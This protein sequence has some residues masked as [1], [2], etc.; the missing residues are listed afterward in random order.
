MVSK[1]VRECR[2]QAG[3]AANSRG[4]Q[5]PEATLKGLFER[6]PEADRGHQGEQHGGAAGD[7][8]LL[9]KDQ[10]GDH[11]SIDRQPQVVLPAVLEIG[12]QEGAS[13]ITEAA[14]DQ[15]SGLLGLDGLIGEEVDREIRQADQPG[16]QVNREGPAGT[17]AMPAG[18]WNRL[19]DLQILS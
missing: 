3:M 12:G 9:A 10:G 13:P 18:F 2:N 5:P 4:A 14:G 1:A 6:Q 11:L 8:H 7:P 19:A 15:G 17:A 16:E